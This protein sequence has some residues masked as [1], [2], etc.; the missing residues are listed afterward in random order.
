MNTFQHFIYYDVKVYAENHVI[1]GCVQFI[2]VVTWQNEKQKNII[3]WKVSINT[4][5][6]KG[7]DL[8]NKLYSIISIIRRLNNVLFTTT[9]KKITFTFI[10]HLFNRFWLPH[11]ILKQNQERNKYN[12][13]DTENKKGSSTSLSLFPVCLFKEC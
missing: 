10:P 6:I 4:V 12:W 9:V 7:V 11:W 2:L 8:E 5:V 13:Q 3:E 1:M